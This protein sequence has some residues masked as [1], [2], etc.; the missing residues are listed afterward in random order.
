M[1]LALEK[2]ERV[3]TRG[4]WRGEIGGEAGVVTGVVAD[5]P[6]IDGL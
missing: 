2:R 4:K 1:N 6:T 5:A 3:S